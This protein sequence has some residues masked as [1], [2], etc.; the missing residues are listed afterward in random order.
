[1]GKQTPLQI[2]VIRDPN[3]RGTDVYVDM[4][5]IAFE[6]SAG[7]TNAESSYLDEAVDLQVQVLDPPDVGQDDFPLDK[8]TRA[9]KHSVVVVLDPHA[10]EEFTQRSHAIRDRVGDDH[11]VLIQ[12]PEIPTGGDVQTTKSMG[13]ERG[14]MPVAVALRTMERSRRVLQESISESGTS[15]R[16]KFFVSHAK[17]DGIPMALSLLSLLDRLRKVDSGGGH[18]YFY[19]VEHLR[20]GENWKKRLELEAKR[21]VLI[22]LR[23]EEYEQR[24]WCRQEYLWA[25][26]MGVPILVVD[27]RHRQ[28]HEGSRLPFGTAPK[29]RVQDG[30][31]IRV[32]FQAMASHLK[33]LRIESGIPHDP[34]DPERSFRD[35]SIVL[36]RRPSEIS[37]DGALRALE[38]HRKSNDHRR[39]MIIYPNPKLSDGHHQAILPMLESKSFEVALITFDELELM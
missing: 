20:V 1:M 31:L 32:V 11:V 28:F 13:L 35:R 12:M 24:Y 27:L 33:A 34:H 23:T 7:D 36:S 38:S 17:I 2:V 30:N 5:R 10:S 16:L 6:G 29:V 37:L 19:D 18:E 8:L 9:A 22:A 21:S 25:E 4:L 26:E 15:E 3:D 14:L 39:A